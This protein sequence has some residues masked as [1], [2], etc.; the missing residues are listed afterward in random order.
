LKNSFMCK[1]RLKRAE[2]ALEKCCTF[3]VK[4][5]G[6]SGLRQAVEASHKATPG[7][8]IRI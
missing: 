8:Q 1:R 3:R 5:T 6:F 4:K 7:G 2:G